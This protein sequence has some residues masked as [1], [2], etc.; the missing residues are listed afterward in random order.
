M[1]LITTQSQ[2]CVAKHD[3]VCYKTLTEDLVS[4]CYDHQYVLGEKIKSVLDNSHGMVTKGLHT[5]VTFERAYY[6]AK[7]TKWQNQRN[8]KLGVYAP[9]VVKC[10]I[11]QGS[12]Y[13]NSQFGLEYASNQLIPLEI[14]YD[15]N[16]LLPL[17]K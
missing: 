8:S 4:P 14:I 13:Y 1:C 11:P 12:H 10:I 16:H 15:K 6:E 3:I 9:I 7:Y 5:F 17:K 2:P